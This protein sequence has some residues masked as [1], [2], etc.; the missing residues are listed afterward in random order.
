MG[1]PDAAGTT[2]ATEAG[3]GSTND[4]GSPGSSDA[5]LSV[6]GGPGPD[7]GVPSPL[8]NFFVSSDTSTT[9]NLGGL[10]GAD[11]RCLRLATA[12]GHGG[13]TWRAYLSADSPVTNARDRIGN[14]P[15][16][17]SLGALVAADNNALHPRNGDPTLFIDEHGGRIN[18]QWAGSPAP[19]QHDILTGSTSTGMLNVGLTCGSWTAT[20]GNSFVGHTD[21]LG[22]AMSMAAMYLP[23]NA[24]HTGQCANTAPGG[25]AG[26]IYC[27]VGN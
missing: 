17:N 4:G 6:E 15:Y 3:G 1:S 2:D 20:T 14:G 10:Q 24:S 9:G 19:L 16:C 21:G 23:W 7:A 25:G 5:S 18:G 27:F 22:P 13:K 26:R 11:A 8:M 12:V